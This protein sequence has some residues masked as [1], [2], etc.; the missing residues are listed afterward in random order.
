VL[1]GVG[2]TTKVDVNIRG[3]TAA[4]VAVA[5]SKSLRVQL[6]IPTPLL[7]KRLNLRLKKTPVRAVIKRLGLIEI[8][9]TSRSS[10][11]KRTR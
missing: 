8:K 4:Q 9:K 6:A 1:S 3:V 7:E 5:L 11:R 10:S 2:L